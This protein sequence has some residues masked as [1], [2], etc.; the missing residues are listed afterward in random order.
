[1]SI[2]RINLTNFTE[3]GQPSPGAAENILQ[4]GNIERV[5]RYIRSLAPNDSED[6]IRQMLTQYMRCIAQANAS[7]EIF[8]SEC[9]EFFSLRLIDYATD[10][11]KN[12][13][14]VITALNASDFFSRRRFTFEHEYVE[15]LSKGR[16]TNGLIPLWNTRFTH[17]L[18]KNLGDLPKMS[19]A[20]AYVLGG[21]QLI[22]GGELEIAIEESLGQPSRRNIRGWSM[23]SAGYA[24]VCL[25]IADA[26]RKS[27]QMK[28]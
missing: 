17:H 22:V 23:V 2:Q 20:A 28:P 15:Y 12:A 8:A 13:Q 19:K 18:S 10:S 9:E 24:L 26:F 16:F 6:E 5:D 4:T 27:F 25:P 11:Q 14:Q 3:L 21:I 1:M 7:R